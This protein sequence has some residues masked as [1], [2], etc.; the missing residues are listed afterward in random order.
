MVAEDPAGSG[1]VVR[2]WDNGIAQPARSQFLL[3]SIAIT[4]FIK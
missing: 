3:D 4:S 1:L 2:R